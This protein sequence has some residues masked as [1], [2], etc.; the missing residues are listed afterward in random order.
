MAG[1][2]GPQKVQQWLTSQQLQLW[3]TAPLSRGGRQFL[4]RRG[5][6][7]FPHGGQRRFQRPRRRRVE[8]DEAGPHGF[9]VIDARLL[10]PVFEQS[11]RLERRSVGRFQPD[12]PPLPI[13]RGVLES[14]PLGQHVAAVKL[15]DNGQPRLL[16]EGHAPTRAPF[17]RRKTETQPRGACRFGRWIFQGRDFIAPRPIVDSSDAATREVPHPSMRRPPWT[18][19]RADKASDRDNPPAHRAARS[20]ASWREAKTLSAR[21]SDARSLPRAARGP[22]GRPASATFPRHSRGAP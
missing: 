7:V 4:E 17:A 18:K 16:V 20:A 9:Q 1:A 10:D 15:P 11:P 22:A 21:R 12:L 2:P 8:L 5:P 13:A 3:L 14:K 6:I 19:N